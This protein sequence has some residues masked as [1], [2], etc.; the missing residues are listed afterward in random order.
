MNASEEMKELEK[1][2]RQMKQAITQI[3]EAFTEAL[4]KRLRGIIF[5]EEEHQPDN[6]RE[7]LRASWMIDKDTRRPH[8]VMMRR[9]VHT[10]RK[11]IP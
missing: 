6:S 3:W 2:W 8:Q 5:G 9:P 11:I 4:G 7:R 1:A 10:P